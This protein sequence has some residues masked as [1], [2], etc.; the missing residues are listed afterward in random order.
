[1]PPSIFSPIAAS[2]PCSFSLHHAWLH[3]ERIRQTPWQSLHRARF[4]L[5]SKSRVIENTARRRCGNETQFPL[6]KSF[7]A[8]P[9]SRLE[10]R[11][12]EF[13]ESSSLHRARGTYG[14]EHR[15][16]DLAASRCDYSHACFALASDQFKRDIGYYRGALHRDLA[17]KRSAHCI[18][19]QR[20][21]PAAVPQHPG[22]S[23]CLSVNLLACLLRLRLRAGGGA[24]T[25]DYDSPVSQ[26]L[27]AMCGG[28]A[29]R[30]VEFLSQQLS[31]L[32]IG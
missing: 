15:R 24:A 13:F 17:A 23:L 4:A 21:L 10:I 26:R 25:L 3:P 2:T 27:T 19:F 11:R 28:K 6:Q 1:M 8:R 5:P 16:F 31:C 12:F 20:S 32:P 30:R 18:L 9:D 29:A 22:E 7:A 14:H